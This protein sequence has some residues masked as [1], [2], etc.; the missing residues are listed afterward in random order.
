MTDLEKNRIKST[1]YDVQGV[2]LEELKD[3][4]VWADHHAFNGDDEL[5][6]VSVQGEVSMRSWEL[7]LDALGVKAIRLKYAA[8]SRNDILYLNKGIDEL[9]ESLTVLNYYEEGEAQMC[10]VVVLTTSDFDV[11]GLDEEGLI[12]VNGRYVNV[13]LEEEALSWTQIQTDLIG[14][15]SIELP[16][17]IGETPTLVEK[18]TDPW[19]RVRYKFGDESDDAVIRASEVLRDE[20]NIITVGEKLLLYNTDTGVYAGYNNTNGDNEEV[21]A[22]DDVKT[23]LADELGDVWTSRRV[24]EIIK[25]VKATTR[26]DSDSLDAGHE[27]EALLSVGN[28]VLNLHTQELQDHDPSYHFVTGVD[29]DWNS[30]ADTSEIRDFFGD[31]FSRDADWKSV[32]E[33]VGN[34]L[35]P[36]YRHQYLLTVTGPGGSGKGVLTTIIKKMIGRENTSSASVHDLQNDQNAVSDLDGSFLNVDTDASGKKITDANL[37]KKLT[38]DDTVATQQKWVQR[39]DFDNEAQ[40]MVVSN[41]PFVIDDDPSAIS[42]RIVPVE[43]PYRFTRTKGDGHGDADPDLP[44]KLSTDE[45]LQALLKMAVDGLQ[46][47]EINNDVSLPETE[48]ERLAKYESLSDPLREFLKVG[49]TESEGDSLRCDTFIAAANAYLENANEPDRS[50][51]QMYDVADKSP[52]IPW[53]KSRETS[54]DRKL[55]LDRVTLTD[56]GKQMCPDGVIDEDPYLGQSDDEAVQAADVTRLTDVESGMNDVRVTVLRNESTGDQPSVDC[57]VECVESGHRMQLI[58]WDSGVDYADDLAVGSDV[59]IT[60]AHY[61]EPDLKLL[62]G[63]SEI[64]VVSLDASSG[65]QSSLD[66]SDGDVS[67]EDRVEAIVSHISNRQTEHGDGV[68]IPDVVDEVPSGKNESYQTIRS[69]LETGTLYDPVQ[70]GQV[71]VIDQ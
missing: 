25:H 51:K 67:Q 49:V 38:G 1:G 23:I 6:E 37:I 22:I 35:H 61:T 60:D 29:T 40:I 71:K 14:D 50:R 13:E 17:E 66:E 26:V 27:H 43:M 7:R 59:V 52:L 62:K 54:G 63:V 4:F 16:K 70:S 53:L 24:D 55:K 48:S 21:G 20:Y 2:S 12:D 15:E 11:N 64:N 65:D 3:D 33:L 19:T 32:M 9:L 57:T 5:E 28:G 31:V 42:R 68:W 46:R 30:D 36:G 47:L 8:T 34:G 18:I 69:L 41:N 45:N 56:D 39:Y 10:D 58:S 44:D